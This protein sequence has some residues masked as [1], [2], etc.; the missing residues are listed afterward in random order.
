M[1]PYFI[2]KIVMDNFSVLSIA[3]F[4]T[5]AFYVWMTFYAS[6]VFIQFSIWDVLKVSLVFLALLLLMAYIFFQDLFKQKIKISLVNILLA[7]VVLFF[8]VMIVNSPY[9]MFFHYYRTFPLLEADL[10]GGWYV[11]TV[12]HTSIIQS[13]TLNGFPSIG[14]HGTPLIFYHVLSHYIDAIIIRLTG[15]DVWDSYGLFYHFKTF[16][17]VSAILLFVTK[18]TY[19]L[20]PVVFFLSFVVVV[21]IIIGTWH[22][23]GSHGLWFAS[24]LM[25]FTAPKVFEVLSRSSSLSSREYGELFFLIVVLALAK[26]SSGFMYG[27]FIGFML[28][29]NHRRDYRVYILGFAWIIFFGFYTSVMIPNSAGHSFVL[30]TLTSLLT[31]LFAIKERMQDVWL[32][33]IYIIVGFVYLFSLVFKSANSFK[34]GVASTLTIIAMAVVTNTNSSLSEHD[35]AYFIYGLLSVLIL[36]AFQ[37]FVKDMATY[38]VGILKDAFKFDVSYTTKVTLIIAM[39]AATSQFNITHYNVFN[40]GIKSIRTCIYNLY[41]QPF[42]MLNSRQK[43][44]SKYFFGEFLSNKENIDLEIKQSTLYAFK[45]GL[46]DFL[47]KNKLKK[48]NVLLFV[49]KEI[50][51][52]EF[53]K[54]DFGGYGDQNWAKGMFIYSLVGVPLI[55]GIQSLRQTYGYKEYNDSALWVAR[56]EFESIEACRFNKTIVI[57]DSFSRLAFSKVDCQGNPPKI[58]V[59]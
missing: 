51:V 59:S 39:V 2:S 52:K 24:I 49:P 18:V 55:H 42:Q 34:V 21:P 9:P 54:F 25:I 57:V 15:L 23:I 30:P 45:S 3:L 6:V 7:S 4:S 11:D 53:D 47:S 36:I 40:A 17:L 50:F 32:G 56:N 8:M 16:I 12:F 35:I 38:K 44:A 48:N 27:T 14:Q 37:R 5:I 58:N 41:I 26:V 22:A 28:L 43:F 29:L 46:N 19:E 13:I 1:K 31:F 33:S 10:G 20:K